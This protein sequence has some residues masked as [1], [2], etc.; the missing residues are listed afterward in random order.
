M[1]YA[2]TVRMSGRSIYRSSRRSQDGACSEKGKDFQVVI[3][4]YQE[5]EESKNVKE[6][7]QRETL[8]CQRNYHIR[9]FRLHEKYKRKFL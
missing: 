6:H 7:C 8:E 9:K 3:L 1:D 2:T 5:K 4:D